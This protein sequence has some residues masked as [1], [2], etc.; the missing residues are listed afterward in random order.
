MDFMMERP[1]L[2]RAKVPQCA[3]GLK[4]VASGKPHQ[5]YTA[6]DVNDE[7]MQQAL[8]EGAVCHHSPEE[9]QPIEGNVYYEGRWQR[10]SALAAKWP[11]ELCEHIL[12]ATEK[13]W[14]KCDQDAPR[15]LADSREP[16]KSHYVMPVEPFPT[17]EGE[18]RKQLE[19][20]D[21]RGGQYDYVF[22]E[23]TARQGPHKIRQALAHLH[24]VLGHPSQERLVR[25]LLISGTSPKIIEMVKGLRCQICQAVRP[26]GAEP[27][28][29]AY[30]PT[31][32]GEKV[33]ADSF[34][35]WDVKGE[36]FNVTHL[37][38]GLT[39]FH[40]GNVSKQVGAEITADLL[41]H[42]WCGIF[43]A[44]EVFQTD[45]G[46]EFE[47]VVHRLSRLLDFRHEVV[48]PGAK[49]RQ[50]QVERHGAVIKLMM[51]R[52]ILTHQVAG[53][54]DMKLVATSCF[55]AKNRL[56]NRQGLSPLQAVTGRN[57]VVPTSIMDQLCSGQVK[58]T[59]NDE[60]QVSEALRRA[61]RIRAAAVDSFNWIDASEALRKA[62]NCRSRPPKL[63]NL[64]EGM[65]VYVHEPPP[66]RRGQHRRL[67]DHSSWDG[68]ALV[69]CVEKQDGAPRR[70]WV[71]LRAKVRSFPLEKIRLA[72]PDEMLG[73]QYVIQAMNEVMDDI[74]N[75][76]LALEENRREATLR[77]ATPAPAGAQ[78]R[79]ADM[80]LDFMLDD[81]EAAVRARQVRRL[82]LQN[83]VP[84]SVRK[85]LSSSSSSAATSVALV[86]G[87]QPAE[88]A[89]LL[90]EDDDMPPLL[91]ESS[92]ELDVTMPTPEAPEPSQLDFQK[93]KQLFEEIS[94][95]PEGMPSVLTE[96]Q[97][98]SQMATTSTRLKNIKKIIRKSRQGRVH[99]DA[100]RRR[101][102]QQVS[103]SIVMYAESVDQA[104]EKTWMEADREMEMHEAFWTQPDREKQAV[105]EIQD[106]IESRDIQHGADLVKGK[107]LTGKERVEFQWQKLDERWRAAFKEPILKAIQIYFDYDALE[108]VPK[109][110]FVDPKRILSSRFVLADKGGH[111]LDE[112]ELKGRLILGG[113]K[114]P[115]M[116]RYSTMA[117]TAALLAHNLINW[118]SVQMGW[119]VHY[120]DVSSAFLQGK[121]L[122]PEREVY[123]R[124][125]KGYPE[126]VEAFIKEKLGELFRQDLLKLTKGRFGLPESPRLWYLEYSDVLNACG[127]GELKLL[128]GVFAA[129]HDDGSLRAVACIHVDDTRYAGDE[130]A[131][132]IW[133]KV[134]QRLRFGKLRKST[135][136]WT[137]FC[138]RWERQNPQTL[139]FEYTM[140]EYAKGIQ[141]MTIRASSENVITKAEQVEMYSLI[142]QLNW[143]ARQGRY[144]LSYGISHVQQMASKQGREALEWLNKVIY[145]AKQPQVQVVRKLD[146]WKNFVVISASDASYGGQPGGRSQGGV[147]VALADQAILDGEAKLCVVEAAS[148]KIQRIVRCSMSAEVSMAA[149]AFEHGDFVRAALAELL[150]RDFSLK[151]WKLW[152]SNWPH[153]LVMD[154]KTGFDVL[155]NES[156][157]SDRKIQIDLAVL[158]QAL[159]EDNAQNFVKWVP[160]HHIISD[161][162]TKWYGNGA[163]T[164][165]LEHGL[166]S[167]KDTT[168]A[169]DLRKEAAKRRQLYKGNARMDRRGD[170]WKQST[171]EPCFPFMVHGARLSLIAAFGCQLPVPGVKGAW[172]V[173]LLLGRCGHSTIM[174]GACLMFRP[175]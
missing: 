72:T 156:Q 88:R 70:V 5:K 97:L 62:L 135:D 116:G 29:S 152:G 102:D 93:K 42:K 3:F 16:G 51:M 77:P 160:G 61:E 31:R 25:M 12:K 125:P 19:K 95:N 13:A 84:E 103:A 128:P 9:H 169:H 144:D 81:Q 104:C 21:W 119:V 7:D 133:D 78:R 120:E 96:A 106:Q 71:R 167:L 75:G 123:V 2:H 33:L 142:G 57:T 24:V 149:T 10:R 146:D 155:T 40:T 30:R 47:D 98:R 111:N 159:M 41:Q 110:K 153:Y 173:C 129:Y 52:V 54:E 108:G 14:E 99:Q 44:P 154:A 163:L 6:F 23:G 90:E 63:E 43:G 86:R 45:G 143:M 141:K 170:V 136:G 65:T 134:H 115:D 117:P 85:A 89:D 118:I 158:K 68:P 22:F 113:H 147:V 130:T 73:S 39:E 175:D 168:E 174:L 127:M 50:G 126:Y 80:D 137:K 67:Q 8:M 34:F 94:Q 53:L 151:K 32:F 28:V 66:S 11:E 164:R 166:W 114:D 165:A 69:V 60:L 132:V 157:T 145:R 109:D 17:P 148:T 74:K 100:R 27:K 49:W 38:D 92:D 82:E 139:E 18:L 162:L 76:K 58:C 4:D 121:H 46:K 161:A 91:D 140:E 105:Q 64:Q 79:G 171:H 172:A 124:L 150:H 131:Q 112:A 20:A 87:L 122:P 26:P 48:P 138:G 15:K 55:N 56:C 107:I 83:D 37:I 35:I 101:G 36:R 1:H 59:V